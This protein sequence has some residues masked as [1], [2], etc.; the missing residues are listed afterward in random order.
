[1]KR[2]GERDGERAKVNRR[3]KKYLNNNLNSIKGKIINVQV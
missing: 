3:R 1:M 2:K